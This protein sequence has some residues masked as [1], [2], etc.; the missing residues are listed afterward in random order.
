LQVFPCRQKQVAVH[1]G[2]GQHGDTA[3]IP[4]SNEDPVQLDSNH[5]L[6]PA[7]S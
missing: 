7:C 1:G 6:T 4:T 2:S 5:L 3:S